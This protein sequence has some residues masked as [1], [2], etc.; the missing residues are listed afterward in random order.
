MPSVVSNRTSSLYPILHSD[1]TDITIR[2]GGIFSSVFPP[3]FR[4]IV[5]PVVYVFA[6]ARSTEG[7]PSFTLEMKVLQRG[8]RKARQCAFI[9]TPYRVILHLLSSQ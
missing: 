1:I 4:S 7:S 5:A 3:R 9:G 2:K 6:A 8:G